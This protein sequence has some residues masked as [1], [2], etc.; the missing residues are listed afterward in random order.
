MT[1]IQRVISDC[2]VEEFLDN[3]DMVEPVGDWKLLVHGDISSWKKKEKFLADKFNSV[4]EKEGLNCEVTV[5]FEAKE[6]GFVIDF[7]EHLQHPYYAVVTWDGHYGEYMRYVTVYRN[8]RDALLEI[9][10]YI[11]HGVHDEKIIPDMIGEL[12]ENRMWDDGDK[13]FVEELCTD[14]MLYDDCRVVVDSDSFMCGDV[15]KCELLDED[16]DSEDYIDDI[17][18]RISMSE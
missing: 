2:L 14:R 12:F 17:V 9:I 6:D 7:S 8:E 18:L 3:C 15:M 10:G 13:Y 5:K 11:V 4:L 1:P 16:A